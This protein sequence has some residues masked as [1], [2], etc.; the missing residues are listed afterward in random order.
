MSL[1]E[2]RY[3]RLA[4]S[5]EYLTDEVV[6]AQAWKKVEHYVRRHN[7]YA[8]VLELD[9]AVLTIESDLTDWAARARDS[10]FR[11]EP[12][13]VVPAPKNCPWSF[14]ASEGDSP[15]SADWAPKEVP[16]PLRPLAHLTVC[17][18]TLATSL[19]L[20]LAD[21]VETLQGPTE[22]SSASAAR[23]QGVYSYG[24]RLWCDWQVQD[25]QAA[26]RARFR[27]GSTA[28]YSGYFEDYRR[29]LARPADL[30][31]IA[32]ARCRAE[33]V[34]YVVELDLKRFFD[35]IDRERLLLRLGK[36]WHL[37][38]RRF[39]HRDPSILS[40]DF[41]EAARRIMDWE[42][43][44]DAET[45][46]KLFE[47]GSSA[48][49]SGG[50]P[51]G[52][53]QGLVASGFLSNAYMLWFDRWI[54]KLLG[55]GKQLIL[56]D[57]CRYVDDIRLVVEVDRAMAQ[58]KVVEL[59]TQR[60]QARLDRYCKGLDEAFKLR[61][62]E[63]K[64]KIVPWADYALQGNASAQMASLQGLI[65]ATPDQDSL[66]Q[67]TAGLDGLLWLSEVIESTDKGLPNPLALS[68]IA[69][70]KLDVRDDTL[71]R[72]V[73]FQ[74]LKSFRLR[75]SMA[76]E[77]QGG[78]SES[79]AI[80]DG[81]S[82]P[83]LEHEMEATAR[84]LVA[85]WS[86][87]PALVP[88]LRCGL[89]L[90]PSP[91]LLQP[92]LDAL[93]LKRSFAPDVDERERAVADYVTAELLRAGAVDIGYRDA[94]LI[95]R[96]ADLD[97]LRQRL[98]G[99]A[100]RVLEEDP[101]APWFLRQQAALFLASVLQ[102]DADL[103][104]DA[105]LAHY[106]LLHDALLFRRPNQAN[107]ERAVLAGL[108]GQQMGAS[109]ARFAI[110]VDDILDRL[111]VCGRGPLVTVLGQMR[112]DLLREAWI[113]HGDNGRGW[114]RNL[115]AHLRPRSYR[116][117]AWNEWGSLGTDPVPLIEVVLR[118]D[119]PFRQENAAL[120]LVAALLDAMVRPEYF[121]DCAS[122][123]LLDLRVVCNRW[124]DPQHPDATFVITAEGGSID[125]RN[126]IPTWC[127]EGVAWAYAVGR[128]LRACVIGDADFTARGFLLREDYARYRGLSSSWFKRRLGLLNTPEGLLGE[129]APLSP[130]LTELIMYL[131]Q[132]P[133][134]RMVDG[135][136]P[137]LGRVETPNQLARI[138]A[139]RRNQQEQLY[140]TQSQ[141]PVYVLP[142]SRG[143]RENARELR[144]AMVQT[145]M[146]RLVDFDVKNP[147]YWSADYRARHR[148]HLAAVC[149][150]VAQ[151]LA[152]ERSAPP[153][154]RRDGQATGVD[155]IVF[156][157]LS[158]HPDD[159][160]LLRSLSDT[161]R[162][163]LFVGLTFQ[164]G[165]DGKPINRALWL[166]RQEREGNR[167]I[168]RVYQGKQHMTK[169]EKDMRVRGERPYQVL[170]ELSG[171]AGTRYRLAG[172]I[173]YDATDLSLATDLRDR[174]DCLVIAAMNRDVPT[175]D[176][177]VQALNYHLFQPV[178]MTNCGEFGGSTAQVPY[179][180][181]H[182][183][184]IAHV[185]GS[186]QVAVSV[187]E[188]DLA[189]FKFGQ[190]EQTNPALKT[191]PA[192]YRGRGH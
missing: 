142:A 90:F 44:A 137:D 4:P 71:K 180:E 181:R 9:L 153:P 173:C 127:R 2:A 138:V 128:I 109:I 47:D 144:V 123:G 146:P 162:S 149:R 155:L 143:Q 12:M 18:Q 38:A 41:I 125:P 63:D 190:K 51:A 79:A 126:T 77:D 124:H 59:V 5:I 170:I 114:T 111:S 65:S 76:S 39:G 121:D 131:L 175:F 74:H 95:P 122:W 34:I 1:V 49:Q 91:D 135:V 16:Q 62:N 110:W 33:R 188:L 21:A 118:P 6:L 139:A 184:V 151:H 58:A 129:P 165:R 161:T 182:Q 84:K 130:W 87:N 172:A 185:H 158:V 191:W 108:I 17:D 35:R 168:V 20:C 187:F 82:R 69:L 140:A 100:R 61:I 134:V 154:H 160:W 55:S 83:V 53:P 107:A 113:A 27:W 105:P 117:G 189:A 80:L 22:Q 75:Q 132:W 13:R 60:I 166:L 86:R 73:A 28:T 145:L 167:E 36:I 81:A 37:Y 57:Y 64:T 150:L 141:L 8:D 101:A 94:E 102:P 52:L 14:P 96:S 192:G 56:Q 147:L 48:G 42:W 169:G 136:V 30:A 148:A 178:V 25:D 177:M 133:G 46:S 120:G 68:R 23:E 152:T 32:D 99:V 179:R 67:A 29:F 78:V 106:K 66:R 11:P 88:V 103:S 171:P 54:G 112:P 98:A 92:V 24:N 174:S 159:L 164:E 186:E 97:E 157:E 104:E 72:F 116:P 89:A 163:N 50:L 176:A 26:P 7:W 31:R 45:H 115:P 119:N 85:S 3:D 15:S 10:D 19:V 183:K 43:S 93:A 70:P 40:P 156:P